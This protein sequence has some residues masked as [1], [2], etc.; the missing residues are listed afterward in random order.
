MYFCLLRL[1][2]R[3]VWCDMRSLLSL[4]LWLR[5]EVLEVSVRGDKHLSTLL[6]TMSHCIPMALWLPVNLF[7]TEEN[8]NATATLCWETHPCLC[9]SFCPSLEWKNVE[10]FAPASIGEAISLF[11]WICLLSCQSRQYLRAQDTSLQSWVCAD[12]SWS[13]HQTGQCHVVFT[14]HPWELL[15]WQTLRTVSPG[16]K[17]CQMHIA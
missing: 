14:R 1:T 10:W 8:I 11:H 15:G 12:Y 6:F 3:V 16:Q 9:L 7:G 4:C 13:L 17:S 2:Q 5:E